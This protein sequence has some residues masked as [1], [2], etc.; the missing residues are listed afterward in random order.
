MSSNVGNGG[1]GPSHSL[2]ECEKN[3][4]KGKIADGGGRGGAEVLMSEGST[5]VGAGAACGELLDRRQFW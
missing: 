2:M 3:N 5:G 4:K 1:T